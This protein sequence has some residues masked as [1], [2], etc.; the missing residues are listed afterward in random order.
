MRI[1]SKLCVRLK[2]IWLRLWLK[3]NWTTTD[4]ILYFPEKFSN[5][6][7]NT[8]T[9]GTHRVSWATHENQKKK[10]WTSVFDAFRINKIL[11]KCRS[12]STF[13]FLYSYSIRAYFLHLS[14]TTRPQFFLMIFIKNFDQCLCTG[15]FLFGKWQQ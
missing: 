14:T 3:L 2:R 1:Y 10:S 12:P 13:F 4:H 7:S 15:L 6:I 9:C 8:R 11:V 5:M